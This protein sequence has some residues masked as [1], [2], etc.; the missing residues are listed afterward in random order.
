M[1]T[2]LGAQLAHRV[3]GAVMAF[4]LPDEPGGADIPNEHLRAEFAWEC[5]GSDCTQTRVYCSQSDSC[6][7]IPE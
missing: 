3:D 5:T 4:Q 2:H 7:P 6:D 1:S